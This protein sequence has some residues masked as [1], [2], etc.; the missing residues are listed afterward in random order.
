MDIPIKNREKVKL[1]FGYWPQFC[2]ARIV[3]FSIKR[4]AHKNY[5]LNISLS[6]IDSEKSVAAVVEISFY[7]VSVINLNS[8]LDDNV[9]DELIIADSS[10]HGE[11]EVTIFPSCGLGGR[12]QCESIE[13]VCVREF[14]L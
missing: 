3:A 7:G 14:Y 6:Y 2:D 4:V 13:V 9:L 8:F 11:F 12:F 10:I 1:L 5:L